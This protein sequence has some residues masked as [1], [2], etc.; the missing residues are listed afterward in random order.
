[1]GR[2][3][4]PSKGAG[5][6]HDKERDPGH[7]V[8]LSDDGKVMGIVPRDQ[9]PMTR[10][11][12]DTQLRAG[13]STQYKAAYIPY[14]IVDGWRQIRKDFAYWRAAVKGVETASSPEERA[15]FEA[16]QRLRE[17]LTMRDIGIWSH[18]VADASQPL[19]V[20]VHFNGWGNFPN[21]EGYTNSKN[22]HAHFEGEFVKKN[23]RRDAVSALV[24]A[25]TTSALAG[26]NGP[27]DLIQVETQALLRLTLAQVV[28]LYEVEKQGGFMVGDPR[29]IE[30]ATARLATGA[31]FIGDM[32]VDA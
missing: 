5:E 26:N 15:W 18:Y 24:P 21:P 22:L 9:L 4:D 17:K 30:F 27:P 1:M 29:E 3:L 8:D 6:T 10:E 11:D 25:Y 12:Y 14:S 2:E 13:G 19:H 28:P 20:S 32:I 7:Y 16:D 23:L 31:Q